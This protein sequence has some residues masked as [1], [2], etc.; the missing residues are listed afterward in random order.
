[1]ANCFHQLNKTRDQDI[2]TNASEFNL[3]TIESI[4]FI[5]RNI[6]IFETYLT[7]H[8]YCVFPVC[9]QSRG[10]KTLRS[11]TRRIQSGFD[12]PLESEGF[13]PSFMKVIR[14]FYI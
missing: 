5:C 12:R 8:A 3:K 9:V 11:K 10:F 7:S 14:M 1:M 13:T 2:V 4:E 6:V